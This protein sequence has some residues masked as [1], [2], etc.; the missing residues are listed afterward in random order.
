MEGGTTSREGKQ[1]GICLFLSAEAG[2]WETISRRG[3]IVPRLWRRLCDK[4]VWSEG[5]HVV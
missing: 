5:K 1:T 4:L 3:C 2:L